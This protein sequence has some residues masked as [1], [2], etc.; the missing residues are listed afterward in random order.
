M[1]F[2]N[3]GPTVQAV[4]PS[5]TDLKPTDSVTDTRLEWTFKSRATPTSGLEPSGSVGNIVQEGSRE[6]CSK[7]QVSTMK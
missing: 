4:E 5:Q 1:K 7:G 3:I 2:I 6:L